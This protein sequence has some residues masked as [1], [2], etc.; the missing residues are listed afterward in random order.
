MKP[1]YIKETPEETEKA[2]KS[3][4]AESDAGLK[5]GATGNDALDAALAGDEDVDLKALVLELFETVGTEKLGRMSMD[6][7]YEGGRAWEEPEKEVDGSNN[8]DVIE[9]NG[10]EEKDTKGDTILASVINR[11]SDMFSNKLMLAV[12]LALILILVFGIARKE[13]PA[14]TKGIRLIKTT[15]NSTELEWDET[16]EAD[17]YRVYRSKDGKKYGYIGSTA[18]PHY[19]DTSVRTGTTYYYTITGRDG[20]KSGMIDPRN[21]VEAT[22]SLD[23]PK[24]EMTTD[25]GSMDLTIEPVEG[26]SG[27]TI[28]RDGEKLA[29]TTETTFTDDKAEGDTDY[30]Y[31]VKAFRYKDLPVYSKQSN[32]IE[33]R[34][35]TLGGVEVETLEDDL[36]FSWEPSEKY[37]TFKIYEGGELVDT[38]PDPAYTISGFAVDRKYDV[39][40]VGYSEDEQV[41]SPEERKTFIVAEEP[42]DNAGAIDAACEWGVSI[43]EDDSFTYGTGNRAHRTGCY[44]CG[45]NVGP[46]INRKG[47]SLVSGHSYE[48]TYCCNPFVHACYAHGAGDQTMLAACRKGKSVGMKESSYTRYGHWKNVGKPSYSDLRRGDVLVKH[49]HVA[50]YLGDGQMVHAGHEGWGADTIEVRDISSKNYGGYSFV[51]RYTGTGNGTKYVIKD[52]DASNPDKD[53]AEPEETAEE[54]NGTES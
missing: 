9:N 19:T 42:M 14:E 8:T 21:S 5:R 31:S 1:E 3:Q 39:S 26:A 35:E 11:L 40:I 53:S 44:F 30:T 37:T 7:L 17:G 47:S 38:V 34:L 32:K 6:D 52:V 25:N 43:A 29:T 51:M 50:L 10:D 24:V 18:E 33:A 15:Y 20:L 16:E 4:L 28:F 46:N 23:K 41:R 36:C 48:K 22:P 13:P 54:T 12:E 27:Y 2:D 45:T 49:S